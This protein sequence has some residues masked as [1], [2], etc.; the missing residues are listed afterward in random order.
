L[1]DDDAGGG[2]ESG[3]CNVGNKEDAAFVSVENVEV[4]GSK[5]R[6]T[7]EC[8]KAV[9]RCQNLGNLWVSSERIQIKLE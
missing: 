8:C 6:I 9:D 2:E 7:R 3:G 4:G 5:K 1:K